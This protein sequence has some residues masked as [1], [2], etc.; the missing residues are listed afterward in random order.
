M[1]DTTTRDTLDRQ[2]TG[3][4]LALAQHIDTA[5]LGVPL[6]ITPPSHADTCFSLA[7]ASHSFDAWLA[8]DLVEV[9]EEDC[10]HGPGRVEILTATVRFAGLIPVR[11]TCARRV[12]ASVPTG[13]AS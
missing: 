10:Q 4:L 6:S 8:S 13:A 7:V 9:L 12:L 5:G 2:S 3:A 11:L 1:N